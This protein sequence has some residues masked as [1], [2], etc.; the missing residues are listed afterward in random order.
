MLRLITLAT[1]SLSVPQVAAADCA[2]VTFDSNVL[3]PA[4][5]NLGDHGGVV[6]A[7]LAFT[8]APKAAPATWKFR[9]GKK[10]TAPTV[11]P[12]APGLD[13]YMPASRGAKLVLEEGGKS[14]I[15]VSA[16]G[17]ARD[18]PVPA[19]KAIKFSES[20]GRHSSATEVAEL[21]GDP[22][23]GV[24]ALVVYDKAGKALSFGTVI[25]NAKQ[26]IVYSHSDCGGPYKGTVPSKT[27]DDVKL[28]WL[29]SGGN[30]SK[31][32]A[33]IRVR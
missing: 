7:Q 15:E 29:D 33:A 32:T 4:S 5:T 30:L 16:T 2:M 31:Q 24:V 13:V 21:V 10:T 28:A 17:A 19:I 12:I 23:D 9:D 14:L 3:T 6:V 18:L 26:V 11:T 1:F 22:P 8:S 25:R 27:G 20:K